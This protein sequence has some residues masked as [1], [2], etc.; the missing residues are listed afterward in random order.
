M[1]TEDKFKA[2]KAP[3]EPKAKPV[4]EGK[5]EDLNEKAIQRI[6][7]A[8]DK[9]AALIVKSDESLVSAESIVELPA[10]VLNS[11]RVKLQEAKSQLAEAELALATKKGKVAKIVASTA[12]A[13][14]ALEAARARLQRQVQDLEDLKA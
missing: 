14:S 4:K 12:D 10:I 8:K 3:K 7:K 5:E 9:L 1:K 11:A 13:I 2:V 6:N